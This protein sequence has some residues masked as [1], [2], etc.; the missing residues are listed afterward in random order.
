M[1]FTYDFSWEKAP[2]KKTLTETLEDID[3]G[4]YFQINRSDI[5]HRESVIDHFEGTSRTLVLVMK[6]PLEKGVRFVVSQRRV[7]EFKW[8]FKEG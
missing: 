3:P 5:V 7:A 4:I 2:W 1:Y 8:W 6:I